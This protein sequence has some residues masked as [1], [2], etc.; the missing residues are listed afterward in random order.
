MKKTLAFSMLLA[1]GLPI[2]AFADGAAI[3]KSR[4]AICHGADGSGNTPTGK[5]LKLKSLGSPEIQKLTDAEIA[6]SL[7]DGKGKMPPTKLPPADIEAVIKFV[8]TLKQ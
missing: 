7:T 3:F 2:A 8:R 1:L 4:C 5:S 6:K